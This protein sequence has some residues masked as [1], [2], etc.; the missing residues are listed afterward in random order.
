MTETK[1]YRVRPVPA[2]H[3][4]RFW[5]FAEPYIKRA[6][7]KT[8]REY[9]VEDFKN[10][11]KTSVLQLWL[12]TEK[13]RVVGAATI[14]VLVYPQ[15][16]ICRVITNAGTNADEWTGQVL[17]PTL[18]DWAKKQGCSTLDAYVRKGYV[19]KLVE[20]GFKHKCSIV[21]KEI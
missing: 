1:E 15:K 13:N 11:C 5:P 12:I 8:T 17:L 4:E 19:P 14:E 16:K 2:E 6:L 20:L 3:V 10:M 21:S 7:D 18:E 9:S